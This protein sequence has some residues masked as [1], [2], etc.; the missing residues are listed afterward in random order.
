MH[1]FKSP[2]LERLPVPDINPESARF[3]GHIEPKPNS[4]SY[5]HYA[6]NYQNLVYVGDVPGGTNY[7]DTLQY[8]RDFDPNTR[9]ITNPVIERLSDLAGDE[10]YLSNPTVENVQFSVDTFDKKPPADFRDKFFSYALNFLDKEYSHI[11]D[12]CIMSDEEITSHIDYTKSCGFPGNSYGFHN[13]QELSCDP[14]YKKYFETHQYLKYKSIWSVHP[15]I[16]FKQ[17]TDLLNNK[18]RLFTIPNYELVYNQIRFGKR[19]SERLKELKWSAYGFNPYKGGTTLLARQLLTMPIRMD[20]DISGWDK[21]LPIMIDIYKWKEKHMSYENMSPLQQ[22]LWRWTVDN[23]IEYR[24]KTPFGEVFDKDYGNA[25]GSGTTTQDN[26]LAHIVILTSALAECYYIKHDKMPPTEL[27]AKQ[28]VRLFGDDS[29]IGLSMEFEYILRDGF[30]EAHFAKFG[31]KLK[32]KHGG[33]NFPLNEL[34]FLGFKFINYRTELWYPKYDVSRLATSA[35]Y[36]GPNNNTQEAYISKLFTLMIMS[37][38]NKDAF[39][40]FNKAYKDLCSNI[41]KQRREKTETEKTFLRMR[42]ITETQI[43]NLF[44]GFE[45]CG[46]KFEDQGCFLPGRIIEDITQWQKI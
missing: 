8:K 25:S 31:M 11:L 18:I 35:L 33:I 36:Q 26:I 13:K 34:T 28:V 4:K 46:H 3:K 32:F 12:D 38:P 37:Y 39:I 27:L 42:N 40:T 5:I 41:E 16:E 24:F 43:D 22:Q 17:K 20:Y 15:K 29:I 14:D 10:F 21:F 6:V 30:L 45:S 7:K 44:I 1:T 19:V 9:L 23:T 2:G